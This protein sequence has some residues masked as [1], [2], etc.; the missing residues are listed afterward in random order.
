MT[1]EPIDLK[2]QEILRKRFC[3]LAIPL[4]EYSFASLYLFREI[5]RYEIL[6]IGGELFIEGVTRDNT[7]YL[8]PTSHPA[9]I[10]PGLI[11]DALSSA[12]ILFP[13]PENWLG[14]FN[15][16]DNCSA[17]YRESDSDYLFARDK[18][19][20]YPGRH[21]D[22]KRNHIHQLLR[23]HSIRCLPLKSSDIDA[24]KVLNQWQE[25]HG[26]E[27]ETDYASCLEAIEKLDLLG[28][29][30]RLLYV[31]DQPAGFVIGEATQASTFVVHFSKAGRQTKGVAEYLFQDLAHSLGQSC[32]WINLE[33]DLGI[34]SLR[35]SKQSYHPDLMLK[36]WRIQSRK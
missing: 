17:E 32:H 3:R 8:M 27:I 5:H 9:D 11:Q 14:E 34:P 30:G 28:L 1:K 21:L 36:K 29:F 19:A 25:Q 23:E 13:I 10:S 6:H 22:G 20:S 33:Q 24:I 31:D 2:H 16:P 35:R 12:E 15:H 26:E 4:S 18:F 7:S